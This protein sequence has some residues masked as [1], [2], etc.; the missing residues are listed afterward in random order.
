GLI[1]AHRAG[2]RADLVGERWLRILSGRLGD[3]VF[4]LAGI[5]VDPPEA[6]PTG[7]RRST[8]V[9]LGLAASR[10]YDELP[11]ESKRRLTGLPSTVRRL[12]ADAGTLR[13]QVKEL[14]AVLSELGDESMGDESMVDGG[15]EGERVR[16]EVEETRD[17]AEARL[18]EVV[19]SLE[20]I[21][22]GLLRM[23]AGESVV[24]SVTMDLESAQRL[25]GDMEDLLEGHREVERLLVRRRATGTISLAE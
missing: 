19:A 3:M 12:E 4:G 17:A 2:R 23:H 24:H 11:K 15:G 7:L 1:R 22:V 13:S 6:R 25:K 16:R 10:L 20:T 14:T 9:A 21:R 18:K 8:E 5:G